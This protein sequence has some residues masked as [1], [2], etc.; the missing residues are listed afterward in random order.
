MG[1]KLDLRLIHCGKLDAFDGIGVHALQLPRLGQG[2]TQQQIAALFRHSLAG[3]I[4]ED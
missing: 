4:S 1:K 3:E 2:L